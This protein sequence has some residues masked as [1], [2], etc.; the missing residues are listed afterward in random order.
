MKTRSLFKHLVVFAV[1][2]GA[3]YA[4]GLLIS[5][6]VEPDWLG[7]LLFILGAMLFAR[8]SM[9]SYVTVLRRQDS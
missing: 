9:K 2:A 1:L 4:Y 8:L 7:L 5:A 6:F 3:L